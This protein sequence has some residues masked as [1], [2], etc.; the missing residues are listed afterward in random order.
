[1]IIEPPVQLSEVLVKFLLGLVCVAIVNLGFVGVA[2]AGVADTA[3]LV[4]TDRT[5]DLNVVRSQFD[6]AD[7]RAKMEEMGVDASAV[8]R[9]LASLNDRELNQL[10]ADMK[11]APAGGDAVWIVGAVFIVLII[12]ELTG[13]IDI[14]KKV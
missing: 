14:F 2:S 10:A 5:A 7:V 13:V 1:M 11:N 3:D 6:R 8:E 4:T 9:R 12:L